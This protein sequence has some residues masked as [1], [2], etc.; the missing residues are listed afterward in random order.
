MLEHLSNKYGPAIV[1]RFNKPN[2]P[3]DLAG[4][5]VGITFN[6]SRR[7]INTVDGHRLMEWCNRTYPEKSDQLMEKLFHAYFEEAKDLS[8]VEELSAIATSV[9]FNEES[10]N[11]FLQSDEYRSEVLQSDQ[12]SK[13]AL[14][15]SG[16][17]YFIIEDNNGG[18]PMA[19]SGAQPPEVI[20]QALEE[21]QEN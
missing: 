2:N 6:K 17:P 1:E 18:R 11:T 9:G 10:V 16:V 14:R 3:L 13:R 20:A 19:F 4:R 8:S 5:N 7:F 15:V 21:A 12:R